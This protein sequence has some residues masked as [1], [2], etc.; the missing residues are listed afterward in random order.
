MY[1]SLEGGIIMFTRPE[2]NPLVYV[3]ENEL[4]LKKT[5]FPQNV[6]IYSD[7]FIMPLA[8]LNDK[9]VIYLS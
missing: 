4:F 6:S 5:L 9:I 7:L 3:P 1:T 2:E 8:K